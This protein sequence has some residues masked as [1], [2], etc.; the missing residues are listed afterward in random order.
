M[1]GTPFAVV[2]LDVPPVT[3]GLAVGSLVAGVA[4]ILVSVLVFCFGATGASAGGVWASGAFTVLGV[5]AGAGAVVAGLLGVRQ[6]RRPAAPPGVRF[7]GRGLAVAGI[8]CGAAGLGL[9]L[10]GLGLAVLLALG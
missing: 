8:S 9:C 1:P 3:S 10:L 5:L 2:H 7:T 6:I 4:A